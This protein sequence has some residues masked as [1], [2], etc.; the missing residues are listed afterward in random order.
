M[1]EDARC[2]EPATVSNARGAQNAPQRVAPGDLPE[3]GTYDQSTGE[4]TYAGE[5]PK[6]EVTYTGGASATFGKESWKW[7]LLQPLMP[8]E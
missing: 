7:L 2:T 1:N 4:F 3:V 6:T 5:A 8:K